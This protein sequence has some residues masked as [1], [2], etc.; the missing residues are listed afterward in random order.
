[1]ITI[2]HNSGCGT[3]RNTLA[4]IRNSGVEPISFWFLILLRVKMSNISKP[5]RAVANLPILSAA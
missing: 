2:Y 3:S 4:L 1:M 5:R